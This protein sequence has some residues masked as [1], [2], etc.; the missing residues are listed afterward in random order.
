MAEGKLEGNKE[1]HRDH[2]LQ[3]HKSL[4]YSDVPFEEFNN[5]LKK[6]GIN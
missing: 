4:S 5:N 1:Q 6:L 2:W 3:Y